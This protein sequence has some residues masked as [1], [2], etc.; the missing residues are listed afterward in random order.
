MHEL[1]DKIFSAIKADL[2]LGC[3]L[4]MQILIA[5]HWHNRHRQGSYA[6]FKS[7]NFF[8]VC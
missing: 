6:A 1:T 3:V 4:S 2:C 5:H 8:S 7:K